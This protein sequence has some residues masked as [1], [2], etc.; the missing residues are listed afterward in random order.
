MDP[1]ASRLL[2]TSLAESGAATSRARTNPDRLRRGRRETTAT[3]RRRPSKN[4]NW[5]P[6]E[7]RAPIHGGHLRTSRETCFPSTT[8]R[9]SLA[10]MLTRT[11]PLLV[12]RQVMDLRSSERRE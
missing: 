1:T 10:K 2:V 11:S 4:L 5:E 6:V 3:A 7:A 8:V 9:T 12:R